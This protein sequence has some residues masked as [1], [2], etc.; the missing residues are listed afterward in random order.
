MSSVEA[1]KIVVHEPA[2]GPGWHETIGLLIEN[3]DPE[4]CFPV[5]VVRSPSDDALERRSRHAWQPQP[6]F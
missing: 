5:G 4:A 2:L 1:K 3:M 6:E